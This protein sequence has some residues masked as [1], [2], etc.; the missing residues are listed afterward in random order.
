MFDRPGA[1][2]CC[3]EDR[4]LRDR[5]S[6]EITTP[7][8]AADTE[9]IGIGD[10]TLDHRL[11]AI[12]QSRD[13]PPPISSCNSAA[14]AAPR[15]ACRADSARARRS[16]WLRALRPIVPID[17]GVVLPLPGGSAMN[18]DHERIALAFFVASRV[19][20]SPSISCPSL[21]QVTISTGQS[22]PSK[23]LP[24]SGPLQF[25]PRLRRYRPRPSCPRR[26][27]RARLLAIG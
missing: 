19:S 22:R 12:D 23:R 21:C 15:P 3:F 13:S 16:R 10:A 5:E 17:K 27:R 9:P 2:H 8:P 26:T 7:R 4:R 1:H 24:N 20:S 18:F 14:K 6:G 11:R 25:C